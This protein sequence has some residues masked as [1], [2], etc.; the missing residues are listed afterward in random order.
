MQNSV[1]DLLGNN[2]HNNNNNVGLVNNL[3]SNLLL[4]FPPQLSPNFLGYMD[5]VFSA[6]GIQEL[7]EF[8]FQYAFFS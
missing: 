1:I 6:R 8:R 2:T 7:R 3:I 4:F 5:T